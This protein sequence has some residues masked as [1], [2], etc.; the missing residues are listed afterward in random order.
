MQKQSFDG[1][2]TVKCTFETEM[3]LFYTIQEP[4]DDAC[5]VILSED[6]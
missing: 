6:R 4:T 3:T 5:T 2:L 1:T